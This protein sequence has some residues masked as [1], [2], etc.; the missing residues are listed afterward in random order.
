MKI[1]TTRINSYLSEIKKCSRE[2]NQLIDQNDLSPN[3]ISMKAAKYTLIELAEA[4]SN[5]VQHI[6]AKG[7][8][9]AVSG[10]IDAISKSHDNGLISKTLFNKLK[11]FFDFRNSLIHRYWIIDDNQLKQNIIEGRDDFELFITEI[12]TYIKRG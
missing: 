6:L 7:M 5:T 11:P 8:G 4:M 2:L 10:Y 3:S 12:E 9:I 1:D